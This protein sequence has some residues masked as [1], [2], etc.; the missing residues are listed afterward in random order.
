MW[1]KEVFF[2][3]SIQ[4]NEV[5]I[6]KD[7]KS[8][9]RY[10]VEIKS[11]KKI[12]IT[13]LKLN[14]L[15]NFE[16]TVNHR[17]TTRQSAFGSKKNLEKVIACPVCGNPSND[18]NEY[19]NIYG[20]EYVHCQH[21]YHLYVLYRP[22]IK[23]LNNFYKTN[24]DYQSTYA[25][26]RTLQIRLRQVVVPKIKYIVGQYKKKWGRLPKSILDVGAGS[27]HF[28][29]ACRN[30]GIDCDGIEISQSGKKFCY[31]NF[32]I[33]LIEDD[34]I[35]NS[36][37]Y[38]YDIVTFFGVIEHI[39]FPNK[40]LKAAQ[41]SLTNRG[42]IL[43]EVPR[44]ESISTASH[45][46]FPESIVRH[47]DPMDHIQC[48][49]DSSIATSFVLSNYEIFSAWYFGMDIYELFSQLAYNYQND[50]FLININ[51]HINNIQQRIDMAKLS[52]LIILVGYPTKH[53][54][55]Q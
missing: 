21:C 5:W 10:N 26:K 40:M 18:A 1:K 32:R 25:D 48:F 37:Q 46:E 54:N 38:L 7:G 39:P 14:F 50:N 55:S 22:Q 2:E 44:L 11:G 34:F 16:K 45:F 13:S 52:D 53:P 41:H 51:P 49:S 42:M 31:E 6:Y 27:G 28:V 9:K 35:S 15:G 29:Y 36:D 33:K 17:K 19:I 30:F 8:R 20:A 4:Q 12:D 43:A 3:S 23:Y 47:L 24:D